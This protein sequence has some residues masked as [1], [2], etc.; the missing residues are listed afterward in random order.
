MAQQ[1]FQGANQPQQQ[2]QQQS[3]PTTGYG[4]YTPPQQTQPQTPPTV[5]PPTTPDGGGS[6]PPQN[7]PQQPSYKSYM[8][9][10]FNAAS[11]ASSWNTSIG[12]MQDRAGAR[13][14]TPNDYASYNAKMKNRQ[15]L[16]EGN[17]NSLQNLITRFKGN[18]F[19][20]GVDP[21]QLFDEYMVNRGGPQDD[22][23]NNLINS[24][25]G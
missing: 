12:R 3:A 7:V 9:N 13:G 16:L 2:Q 1:W 14:M 4:T 6:I 24:M 19:G 15:G 22:Y 10:I 20:E 11:N 23:M 18:E 21:R 5:T 17:K 8:D 25:W